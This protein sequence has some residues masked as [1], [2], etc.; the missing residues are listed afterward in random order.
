MTEP[1]RRSVMKVSHI[2][3]AA[4]A[5]IATTAVMVVIAT[6]FGGIEV[7][8]AR[9]EANQQVSAE[10]AMRTYVV[11]KATELAFDGAKMET[12]SDGT[13][14]RIRTPT[15]PP[16][17]G[18]H[19]I[20]DHAIEN[21]ALSVIDPGTGELVRVSSSV[22]DA[23]GKRLMI[24]SR[25]PADSDVAKT[26]GR[27]EP[28][29]AYANVAGVTRISRYVPIVAL[30]GK[31]LGAIGT[32]MSINSV[33]EQQWQRIE[34]I[35][36]VFGLLGVIVG[37]ATYALLGSMLRPVRQISEAI[38]ALAQ[39]REPQVDAQLRR[40]DEIG[41]IARSMKTLGVSLQAAE[42]ERQERAARE[43]DERESL[44]RRLKLGSEFIA[45]MQDL[46]GHFA[47]SSGDVA[48]SAKNLAST[49]EETSRQ[50]QA[51]AAAAEQAA[52]SVQTV[53]SS[54]EEIATSVREIGSQV[55]HSAAVADKAFREAEESN[56]RIAEL[57]TAASAI[58]DVVG[59]ISNIAGQTNLLALNAT[60][61]AARA[62]EAGR[63]FAV[64]AAEVKQLAD[65]TAKATGD[66]SGKVVEIQRATDGTVKSMT[67][68]VRVI[69]D[70]KS[71]ASTIAGAVDEQEA[72]TAEIA[73]NC[74]QAA[75]GT[76]QVT[77]NIAGVGQAA[78]M[79]G[80]A[81]T[82]LMALSNNL[83]GRAAELQREVTEF[84]QTLR[85]A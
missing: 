42:R 1:C 36:I 45:R 62:G 85:T 61:E 44:A 31:P 63:G 26:I 59:L 25:V 19:R 48:D 64:V 66:I 49:A 79:T 28:L 72:S 81:S 78:E 70:I 10:L 20:V 3:L 82:Q 74:H 39:Q 65:Q 11:S 41:L 51:V 7:F 43:T 53:A 21:A 15:F 33:Q 16:K 37:C 18:D 76:Q 50:A 57:A 35:L 71:I 14:A 54:S 75:T 46:A 77:E 17:P 8:F 24:G 29:T 9:Q 47:Q 12:N 56:A 52:M 23:D 69:G 38:D 13:V 6:A 67:E 80:S 34:R 60:I 73:N 32:G 27:G 83:T 2:G 58:G 4:K 22:L 55:E 84:M 30:D 5:S 40:K 68:I